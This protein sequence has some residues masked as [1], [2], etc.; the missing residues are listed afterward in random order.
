MTKTYA[1]TLER[2]A[3]VVAP[4][5]VS[6]SLSRLCFKSLRQEHSDLSLEYT[7]DRSMHLVVQYY[8]P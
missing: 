1:L 7:R 2:T 3:I 8:Y 6:V 4:A 5:L